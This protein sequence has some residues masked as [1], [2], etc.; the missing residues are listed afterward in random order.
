MSENDTRVLDISALL[1]GRRKLLALTAFVGATVAVTYAFV[2]PKWYS[3]TLT[4]V[5]SQQSQNSAAMSLASKLPVSL[6]MVSTDV[7]RIQAV[8]R[9]ASVT[10]QVIDKFKLEDY[11]GTD[12]REQARKALWSHC[13][14]GVDRK[15]GVVA[16]TCEDT[17]PK[18]AMQLAEYFGEVGNQVFG[19][20]SVSS[21]R[22]ERV[23]L[24]S[25]VEKARK[26]VDDSSKKLRDFQEAH[27]I[28]DLPEQSKAVISAMA[29]IKGELISKQLELSYLSSFSASSESSVVQLQQQIAIMQSKLKQLEDAEQLSG[30]ALHSAGSAAGSATAG[31]VGSGSDSEF[32]PG[33]MTVPDLRLQ[34]EDLMRE[35]KI[36]ETVFSLM[37]QRYEMAR[38]DEARDTSTFQILDH[39]TLPTQHS[40]PKKR[41]FAI[42]GLVGGF[43]LGALWVV[44]PVWWRKQTSKQPATTS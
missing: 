36:K 10:D 7:M 40:R 42:V 1:F 18:R 28:I 26:D 37:T 2:A 19:R 5:Q 6:D 22:E 27:K 8:F 44:V 34:L 32:F 12:H 15:A 23:F 20:V 39:P 14:T 3:A 30:S 31:H 33:A 4:V 24:E 41:M 38:V 9:S 35:Q 13:S 29:S 25:Q 17:D 43:I 16:L 21:A 11:Y